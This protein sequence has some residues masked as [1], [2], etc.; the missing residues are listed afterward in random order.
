MSKFFSMSDVTAL[1]L[2]G[3]K[4]T[5]LFPLT[6]ER[7]KPAV[8]LAGE[9]RLI[10][11]PLSNCINSRIEN[12]YVITQFLSHSLHKHVNN[13][14][15]FDIFGNKCIDILAASQG[16]D[17]ENWFQGTAD[18]VRQS[19]KVVFGGVS[20]SEK[21]LILSGDQIYRMDF[22]KVVEEHNENNADLTIAVTV[23]PAREAHGLGCMLV[24]ENLKIV[25]FVEKP[26]GDAV[27]E[28]IL[29]Q[30]F[31]DKYNIKVSEP[32]VLV[33]MGIY[34]FET[35]QLLEC[36]DNDMQDFGKNI[37]PKAINELNVYAD[38]FEGYW[39]DIGTIRSFFEA[40]L[41][42]TDTLPPFDFYNEK[43]PIYSASTFLPCSKINGRSMFDRTMV[44]PGAIIENSTI[45]RSIIGIRSVI[46]DNC[47]LDNVIMM[48]QDDY[49]IDDTGYQKGIGKGC[50]ITRAIIDK[51]AHIGDNVI[52]MSQ[53]GKSDFDGDFYYIRDG[54][55]IIPK[56][57]IVPNNTII[58]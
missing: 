12:I 43:A 36:L 54:I 37:I 56:N 3:G 34:L 23:K 25:K 26:K 30:E 4:G 48:G 21:T 28:L 13:A 51:N 2:G 16:V 50:R 6:K 58:N 45:S 55:T 19:L 57:A 20:Y 32:S 40:N 42:L 52:I 39:E 53:E 44:S 27:N 10:D 15:K 47:V 29:P 38:L 11:I 18:A 5:R 35:E 14:Y 8:P 9:F 31:L 46:K 17:G 49:T 7:A 24:D 1:V 33:S 22:R 41:A